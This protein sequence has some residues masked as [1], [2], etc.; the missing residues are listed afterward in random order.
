VTRARPLR[1]AALAIVA[2]A[3]GAC[4]VGPNYRV[5][6]QALVN[7]PAANAAFVGAGEDPSVT[8]DAVPQSWWRLYDDP[9]LD[10]LIAS[11]LAA[12]TDLRIASGAL[13]RSE[14]LLEEARTLRQ[15]NIAIDAG[16]ERS[17][18]AGEDYLLRIRPPESSDY[19]ASITVGYDLDLF[20]AIRR[21]IEEAS[22]DRDAVLAARDL[23]RVNVVAETARAWVDICGAGLEL[24]SAEEILRTQRAS[25]EL[26]E[27]L[28]SAG[29]ATELDATRARQVLRQ[30]ESTLP[31]F[32]AAQR[33]AVFRLAVLTGRTPAEFDEASARCAS[34]PRLQQPLPIG[35]GTALLKRRP[36]VRR[37]ERQLAAA[38]AAIGVATADLYPDVRLG[39]SL[40]SLGVIR[41]FLTAPTNFWN[42]GSIL[43]WQA[44]QSAA[45]AR[46]AAA[47]AGAVIALANFDGV[48]LRSLEDVESALNTYVHDLRRE[49]SVAAARDEARKAADDALR[50]Q[51]AGRADA[52]AVVDAQR[53]LAS[54]DQE[55]AR[56]RVAIAADQIAVFLA[57]GGGWTSDADSATAS[58][59]AAN[60]SPAT[61][62]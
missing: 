49:T 13:A 52:F 58:T 39:L 35:D 60:A 16:V 18:V 30:Q 11:A 55:L 3:L 17:Q 59:A 57:L 24:A 36:D 56:V 32:E 7:S 5:P 29:R 10:A 37:A 53:T 4:A 20:G 47:D 9:A 51:A 62:R 48:V 14:A 44:N 42:I 41:D 31:V 45:R 26:T 43:H 23:V 54:V 21:G 40:G 12:N 50:L 2:A 25:F 61:P 27:R 33:N 15:P 22:A 38:T 19:K 6:E 46:I 34:P 8:T 1:C 28:R